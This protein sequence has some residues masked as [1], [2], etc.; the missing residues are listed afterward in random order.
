[1]ERI[2][3]LKTLQR[4]E[5]AKRSM[6]D[7]VDV[8]R[9][10]TCSRDYCNPQSEPDLIAL[11]VLRPPALS[12]D[13]YLCRY[14]SYHVCTHDTCQLAYYGVCP[15]SGHCYGP[16]GGVSN[17]DSSDW[18]TWGKQNTLHA[19][20]SANNPNEATT[21][22]LTQLRNNDDVTNSTA[23]QQ[24]QQQQ[25]KRQR[26][27]RK[28]Y[29]PQKVRL[30]IE[31]LIFKILYSDTRKKLHNQYFENLDNRKRKIQKSYLEQWEQQRQPPNLIVLSM[32]HDNFR[33][34]SSRNMRGAIPIIPHPLGQ[35]AYYTEYVFRV[36][37]LVS[38]LLAKAEDKKFVKL[39]PR[40]ITL[41]TLYFMR[42]GYRRNDVEILP[43][44]KFL[45]HTLPGINELPKFDIEKPWITKGKSL[46][47][48]ALDYGFTKQ[49]PRDQLTVS[50]YELSD[51]NTDWGGK[52]LMP[53]NRHKRRNK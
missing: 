53:V 15:I 26:L 47:E 46:I 1:M 22:S 10:H 2:R 45:Q 39:D 24:Q 5:S 44:D 29:N 36:W 48:R 21:H 12:N 52:I 31:K 8:E 50:L 41:A 34:N 27:T 51:K 23:Q 49:L 13:V 19:T 6:G 20:H 25:L 9:S 38:A 35:H 42:Q 30:L 28:P 37:Q 16:Q 18:R 7:I 32:I 11:G 17:Y 43:L 33:A 14:M 4:I 40:Y 3:L